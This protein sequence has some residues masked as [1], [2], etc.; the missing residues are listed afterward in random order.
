[1]EDEGDEDDPQYEIRGQAG[2]PV[3]VGHESCRQRTWE[4]GKLHSGL[5]E[6]KELEPV[7]NSPS[8][9]A[10]TGRRADWGSVSPAYGHVKSALVKC[11]MKENPGTSILVMKGEHGQEVPCDLGQVTAILGIIPPLQGT[12]DRTPSHPLSEGTLHPW[13]QYPRRPASEKAHFGLGYKIR[14]HGMGKRRM[15][16]PL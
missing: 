2:H 12:Q 16:R 7:E 4:P 15:R 11:N 3:P 6:E 1:M 10:A 5:R 9:N 13:H 8:F 14:G